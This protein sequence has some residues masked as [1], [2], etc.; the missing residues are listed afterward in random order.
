LLLLLLMLLLLLPVVLQLSN[1]LYNSQGQLQLCD[2][3]LAR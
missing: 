2:F 1:L 3:G